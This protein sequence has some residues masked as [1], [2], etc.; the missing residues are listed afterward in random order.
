MSITPWTQPEREEGGGKVPVYQ[1][2]VSQIM[3]HQQELEGIVLQVYM[4]MLD[5]DQGVPTSTSS[6]P[7]TL[8]MQHDACTKHSMP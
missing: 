2:T 8:Q 3:A 1:V 4:Q 7:T 6:G 5:A